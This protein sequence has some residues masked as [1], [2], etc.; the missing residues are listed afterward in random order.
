[1]IHTILII[2]L[3]TLYTLLGCDIHLKQNKRKTMKKEENQQ[4]FENESETNNFLAK[5]NH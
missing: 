4:T 3:F 2:L 1:M 5:K